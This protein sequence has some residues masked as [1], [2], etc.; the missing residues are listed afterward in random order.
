[1]NYLSKT[2]SQDI[3]NKVPQVTLV[4]WIVKVMATTVGETGADFLNVKLGFGLSGTSIVMG[5]LLLAILLIQIRSKRYIPW[6]YWLA[7]VIVSVVGTLITDNLTDNLGVSLFVSSGVFTV[8]LAATFIAWYASE[9]T[10][11]RRESANYSIGLP[12]SSPS[13]SAPRPA[14]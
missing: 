11:S 3:I 13:P 5:V 2:L 14:I 7:V 8:A 12:F 6:I 9:R 4:F 10:R 1:M